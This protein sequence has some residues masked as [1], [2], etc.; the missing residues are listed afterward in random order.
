MAKIWAVRQ[1]L[2]T[3]EEILYMP[4]LASKVGLLLTWGEMPA[5]ESIP[6]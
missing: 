4:G 2:D 1:L 5:Y 3:K 6:V